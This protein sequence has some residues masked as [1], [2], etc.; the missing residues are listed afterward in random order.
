MRVQEMK[1]RLVTSATL[2]RLSVALSVAHVLV[3]HLGAR[4]M[5][6]PWV[7]VG[8]VLINIALWIVVK[9]QRD[10]IT[11]SRQN[12]AMSRQLV[13]AVWLVGISI[14]VSTVLLVFWSRNPGFASWALVLSLS[15][16]FAATSAYRDAVFRAL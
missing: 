16:L 5:P 3:A 10:A 7:I 4:T 8:L 13:W 6:P 12:N 11:G 14:V 2:C 1:K 9:H 15:Y